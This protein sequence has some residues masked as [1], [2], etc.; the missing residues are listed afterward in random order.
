[1]VW[2]ASLDAVIGAYTKASDYDKLVANVEYLQTLANVDHDF[3]ISTGTGKHKTVQFLADSTYNIG[4]AAVRAATV[5]TDTLGDS[6]QALAVAATTVNLPSGFGFSWDAGDVTLTHSSNTLTIA[7]VA[8]RVDLAAGILEMNNAIEWDTGVAVVAAEYS[9]GRDADATNQLHFN[10]P[11][12]AGYEWSVNDVATVTLSAT[13]ATFGSAVTGIV[14][15]DNVY[16][17]LGAGA[18]RIE[19]DDQSTD[20]INFLNCRIGV[21]TS[22]PQNT[23]DIG[24][25]QNFG[26]MLMVRGA[27]GPISSMEATANTTAILNLQYIGLTPD[28]NTQGFLTCQDATATR[29]QI[30]SDGDVQNHD[31]SYGALSD[32]TLKQDIA[33]ARSY[34]EDWKQIQY[35]KFRFI[36]D[37]EA[38]A[39]APYLLG[40]V[41]QEIETVFPSIIHTDL[42]TGYKGVK[43]SVMDVIAGRVLQECIERIEALEQAA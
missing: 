2:T 6:G 31:N 8:T 18:G 19:F 7:G 33:N 9:V 3:H 17:G 43:Y 24:G 13:T 15:P 40:V 10:V 35:R 26:C 14:V 23:V 34:W 21:G 11:T 42:T 27:T 1:M 25:G 20:G 29:L 41:A 12:G 22:T 16:I 5:F 28:N 32:Q 30:W 38:D 4:S 36:S 39:N 37:V